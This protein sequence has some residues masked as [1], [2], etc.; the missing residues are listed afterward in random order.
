M[1]K[2]KRLVLVV[3]ENAV[4]QVKKLLTAIAELSQ[5]KIEIASEDE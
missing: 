2:Q 1:A 5:Q 4:K 3:D